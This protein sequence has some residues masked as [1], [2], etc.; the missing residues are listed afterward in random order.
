MK[1]EKL[2]EALLAQKKEVDDIEL[3]VSRLTKSLVDRVPGPFGYKDVIRAFFGALFVGINFVFAGRLITVAL[4]LNWSN[5]FVISLVNIAILSGGIYFI[6]YRKITNKEERPFFQFWLKRLI[7]FLIVSIIVSFGLVYLFAVYS[8]PG[9][10]TS[11]DLLRVV[12]II[13]IPTSIGAAM[14]DLLKQY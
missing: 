6:G 13:S 11:F 1:K 8:E 4:N 12:A 5:M 7:A 2:R 9:I 14:G 3:K 10:Y